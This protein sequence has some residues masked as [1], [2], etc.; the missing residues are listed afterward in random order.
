[1]LG[2]VVLAFLVVVAAGRMDPLAMPNPK[3]WERSRPS[4]EKS[5][6]SFLEQKGYV[7][8]TPDQK[9]KAVDVVLETD[10]VLRRELG[11]QFLELS[12]GGL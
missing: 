1:M 3:G 4:V 7:G 11:E 6:E 5:L 2:S 12:E 10:R 8:M 9:L